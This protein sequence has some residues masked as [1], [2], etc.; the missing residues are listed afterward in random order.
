[1]DFHYTRTEA[2]TAAPAAVW[3]LWSD[4]G[5]WAAWDPAVDAVTLDGDFAEGA[6]GTMVLS[7]G[8]ETPFTLE[9]VEPGARYL[10]QLT[11]GELVIRIDHVVVATETG[12]D[13]T[14]TTAISGPGAQD[15][16][17]LVT[18][19]APTAMATL[20]AMAEGRPPA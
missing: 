9:V 18:R 7:G 17:P 10:D 16:G 11:M 13:V 8:I 12:S 15:I 20:V 3:A 14:V 1:M 4:P 2:T 5:T 6:A 19:D